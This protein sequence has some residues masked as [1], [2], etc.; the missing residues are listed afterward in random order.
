MSKL[1]KILFSILFFFRI[2]SS[3]AQEIF[4]KN[5]EHDI[6][7]MRVGE[8]KV[9]F[10]SLIGT[11]RDLQKVRMEVLVPEGF[12]LITNISEI[13]SLKVGELKS[14]FF[15][16][17]AETNTR[18]GKYPIKLRLL[19]KQVELVS[20]PIFLNL[21]K[22]QKIEIVPLELPDKLSQ[23]SQEEVSFLV[24]N[25]GN[26]TEELELSSR[27]GFILGLSKII[28]EP[29]QSQII[30]TRNDLPKTNQEIRLASFDLQATVKGT[31]KPFSANF[32]IPI[33]S[34]QTTKSDAYQRFPIVASLIW[35]QYRAPGNKL[36]ALTFDV[37][38]KGFV[39][40][41]NKHL[42]EF[43]AK[44]PNNFNLPRF[45]SIN[46]YFV[47]YKTGPWKLD[48]GDK[49]FA[50]SEL[51][52]NSRFAKGLDFGRKIGDKQISIFYLKPR[53]IKTISDEYGATLSQKFNEQFNSSLTYLHKNHELN[54]VWTKS[55]FL[56]LRSEYAK[57]SYK[58]RGEISVSKT[59]RSLSSGMFYNSSLELKKFRVFTNA[60]FTGKKYYGFYNNSLLFNNSA[61][62][63]L[64]K[65]IGLGISNNISQINPSL[66]EFIY[67][68]SPYFSNN[69]ISINYDLNKKHTLRFNLIK[70]TREDKMPIKTYHYK[71]QLSRYYY[72]YKNKKFTS[73]IDGDIGKTLNLLEPKDQQRFSN[74][75][76]YRGS[77]GYSPRRN[78]GVLIFAEHLNTT[79]FST[80]SKQ[81]KFWFYG[82]NTSVNLRNSLTLN[83]NYRNNFSPDEFYQ[84]QSFFD[85]S[86]NYRFKN[87]EL[88]LMANYSYIPAPINDKNFFATVKY[89]VHL[90][91][92]I[93]KKK[94]LGIVLGKLDGVKKA[95]VLL[96]L[97]GKHVMTDSE[98][99]FVFND[100]LPGKYYLGVTK[101]S[102][103]FG[104]LVD[105]NMPYL[106]EINPQEKKNITLNV[107]NT[108]KVK[109][110]VAL[111]NS[112]KRNLENILVE[113]YVDNF[114]KVTTT[115]AQGNFQ[116]SELKEG[117]YSLRILSENIKSQ[118]L[119]SNNNL[120][121]EITKGTESFTTFNMEEKKK[122]VNF[123]K[124][125][126]ILTDL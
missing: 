77:V 43:I 4:T 14:L 20:Y 11:D 36:Q 1:V 119:I 125:K 101:S 123:Q 28:L 55:D 59:M 110:S 93:R 84:S 51:T 64:S 105:E 124:E 45:G 15:T 30:K 10:C 22:N 80:S 98:G 6:L 108:G 5:T 92:P 2:P 50:I 8:K 112:E 66:D 103:G 96:N 88:S 13:T 74:S 3:V 106:V 18:F 79:R 81:S 65:K 86:V 25:N 40:S 95:G 23:K 60:I 107:I 120:N 102:L 24:K 46:Q 69:T 113:I 97:N 85:A 78:L 42:I 58:A 41:Q 90:N 49:M 116:F 121:V 94:G 48:L 47:S 12:R 109:G 63:G 118:F 126:I 19:E 35:N 32:T 61:F 68:V 87:Q 31:E 73:R 33:M 21:I 83:L 122:K 27:S 54:K 89:T 111:K 72:E 53:F 44:G 82:I 37:T 38:G 99:K 52:D 67:T 62:Y 57:G 39:D 115:D 29:G 71:E 114:S 34:F 117:A 7:E 16:I 91:T 70:G 56:S 76:R 100:L 9:V 17:Q 75:Y 26:A 104:N